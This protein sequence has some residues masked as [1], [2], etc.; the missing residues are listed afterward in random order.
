[1]RAVQHAQRR[2]PEW[3]LQTVTMLGLLAALAVSHLGIYVH[4]LVPRLP[5]MPRGPEGLWLVYAAPPLV[6]CVAAGLRL[7]GWR[8]VAAHACGAAGVHCAFLSSLWHSG[9]P[10]YLKADDYGVLDSVVLGLLLLP[11]YALLFAGAA[12]ISSW[13]RMRGAGDPELEEVARP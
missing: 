4:F 5:D 13:L 11:L 12:A 10:G 1:M 7:R 3:L 9:A 2:P 8:A 6:V